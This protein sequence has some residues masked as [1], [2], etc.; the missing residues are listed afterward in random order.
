MWCRRSDVIV[1]STSKDLKMIIGR[2]GAKESNIRIDGLYSFGRKA[3]QTIGGCVKTFN[4]ILSRKGSL[5]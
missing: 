4:P 3:I 1:A 2:N 5:E